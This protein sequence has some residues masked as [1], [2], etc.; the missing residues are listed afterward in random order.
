MIRV[1][2]RGDLPGDKYLRFT[3]I[4]CK[5]ILEARDDDMPMVGYERKRPMYAFTCPVCG[6]YQY[7][8]DV[9]IREV[10]HA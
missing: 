9:D 1:I 10:R 6:E 2:R 4:R 7:V 5:S 8:S 3:C